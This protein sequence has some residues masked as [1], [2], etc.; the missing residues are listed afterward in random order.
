MRF[1]MAAC[2]GGSRKKSTPGLGEEEPIR[3]DQNA[4]GAGVPG[5]FHSVGRMAAGP[6]V[7]RPR[8]R[9]V[10]R[11]SSSRAANSTGAK[12]DSCRKDG[13]APFASEWRGGAGCAAGGGPAPRLPGGTEAWGP[14]H[15]REGLRRGGGRKP[16]ALPYGGGCDR[17][18]SDTRHDTGSGKEGPAFRQGGPSG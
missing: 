13:P 11:L 9:R 1:R 6:G 10:A 3:Q 5:A 15:C 8:T 12:R 2:A 7:Q 17:E 16:P 18:A 4:R 14:F